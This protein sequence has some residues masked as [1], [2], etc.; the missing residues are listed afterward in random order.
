[1]DKTPRI[2]PQR[3]DE[4]S[5]EARDMFAV[6]EGPEAREKGSVSNLVLTLAHYPKLALAFLK[7]G[8]RMVGAGKLSGR[9]REVIVLR[10][11]WRTQ[12]EYEWAQHVEIGAKVGL[13]PDHIEAIKAAGSDSPLWS[14]LERHAI[15][16]TDQLAAKAQIDDSTWAGLA[17][18]LDTQQL[19]ELIFVIG[20][21]TTVAW[22]INSLGIRPE[23]DVAGLSKDWMKRI[24]T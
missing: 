22:L 14:V 15:D 2:A 4:W 10:I 16:A 19:I 18:E 7:F 21:Y 9:L 8:G 24:K 20:N 5:D 13:G 6:F 1:M 11:A 23:E 3:P 17:K 12:S